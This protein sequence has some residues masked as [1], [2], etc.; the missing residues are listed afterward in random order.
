[1]MPALCPVA[2]HLYVREPV[3]ARQAALATPGSNLDERSGRVLARWRAGSQVHA[4]WLHA[5]GDNTMS[6]TATVTTGEEPFE[7]SGVRPRARHTTSA[8]APRFRALEAGR[9]R[10]GMTST[11]APTTPRIRHR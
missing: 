7:V 5:F 8:P 4:N 1:M 9:W 6:N 3:G 2:L 11:S 10:R